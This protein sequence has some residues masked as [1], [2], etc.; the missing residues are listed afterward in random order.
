M[1]RFTLFLLMVAALMSGRASETWSQFLTMETD[2]AEYVT[3]KDTTV[4]FPPVDTTHYEPVDTG[5]VV[6]PDIPSKPVIYVPTIREEDNVT[7]YPHNPAADG[8]QQEFAMSIEGDY[9]RIKGTLMARGYGKHYIHCQIIGDS[10]HLQRFDMDPESTDM[11]LHN[12]DI[13]IPGF[14]EDYYKVT[15]AEQNDVPLYK[16]YM[17]MAKAVTRSERKSNVITEEGKEWTIHSQGVSTNAPMI[18]HKMTIEG[19][20]IVNGEIR[21]KLHYKT[22]NEYGNESHFWVDC[23]QEG[24]VFYKRGIK[25]FDFGLQVG[26]TIHISKYEILAVTNIENIVLNDG[27]SR[28]CLSM[29]IWES[30]SKVSSAMDKW[31]EG[32]GSLEMG[33]FDNSVRKTG[34]KDELQSVIMNNEYIYKKEVNSTYPLTPVIIKG[35]TIPEKPSTDDNVNFSIELGIFYGNYPYNHQ[36]DSI[37]GNTVYTSGTYNRYGHAL[38][39]FN[40][41]K[42]FTLGKLKEGD[43]TLYHNIQALNGDAPTDVHATY[44]YYF[45]VY[46]TNGS[47]SEVHPTTLFV[48]EGKTWTCSGYNAISPNTGK[49]YYE[50]LYY[51]QGDSIIDG[52]VY[53]CLHCRNEYIGG[54]RQDNISYL[55]RQEGNKVY[56]HKGN[57]LYDFELKVGEISQ[58]GWLVTSAGDTVFNDNIKRRFLK[59]KYENTPQYGEASYTYD[60]WV[61]GLG[62]LNTGIEPDKDAQKIGGS[63]KLQGIAQNGTYIY[64]K[65][66]ETHRIN[67]I[68]AENKVWHSEK[69]KSGF[70]EKED[71]YY[72]IAGDTVIN[73]RLCKKVYAKYGNENTQKHYLASMYEDG[74]KVYICH[75]GQESF[76]LLYDFG[77]NMGERVVID[78]TCLKVIGTDEININGTNLRRIHLTQIETEESEYST[79][80]VE[81]FGNLINPICSTPSYPGTYE[82]LLDC[83]INGEVEL[84]A[85]NLFSPQKNPSW[86][87]STWSYFTYKGDDYEFIRYTLL[88]EPKSINGKTY[89]PLVQYTSCEYSPE[90]E[91]GRWYI[92]KENNIVYMNANYGKFDNDEIFLNMIDDDYILYDFNYVKGKDYCYASTLETISMTDTVPVYDEDGKQHHAIML[93]YGKRLIDGIGSTESLV[94]LFTLS[95]PDC[96]CGSELNFFRTADGKTMYKNTNT[97]EYAGLKK[98]DCALGLTAIEDIIKQKDFVQIQVTAS[99]LFCTAPDA[100]KLELYTMDAIKVGEARFVDGKATVKVGETPA[101]YLYIVTYPD[102]RRESGKV[103]VNEE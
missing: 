64:N 8:S 73:N 76:N 70:K 62:S 4:Y 77:A 93:D 66:T 61:E 29:G 85:D 60:T 10:V 100:V 59:V 101:M 69:W 63:L 30:D 83:K 3:P 7:E 54:I 68:L 48:T 50:R 102:G 18:I 16:Q 52:V 2:T 32:I 57:V 95:E 5:G 34:S 82:S 97:D 65:S 13:R 12:V 78:N 55:L 11:I 27:I 21:K 42:T 67:S 44:T 24:D 28:K 96:I 23:H 56:T 41:T 36:I 19:D 74:Y 38:A 14:T 103:R 99:T 25:M 75:A 72:H 37:V 31:I 98:D 94:T 6:R 92:R 40:Q 47:A 58:D 26:D 49:D 39:E 53:K 17:V 51:F 33:I 20:T 9:L 87:G 90:K 80:W 1:K 84:K 43:Y 89:L 86:L 35:Y 81:G 45:K 91:L 88:D 22:I 79:I 15:L 71:I 46:G